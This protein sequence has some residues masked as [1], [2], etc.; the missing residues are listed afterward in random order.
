VAPQAL[1]SRGPLEVAPPCTRQRN[2]HHLSSIPTTDKY[3]SLRI[4]RHRR[5]VIP[6]IRDR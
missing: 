6:L 5:S 2:S 3:H 4:V 1:V